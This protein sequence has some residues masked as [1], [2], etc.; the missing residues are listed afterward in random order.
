[1]VT[2]RQLRTTKEIY[3]NESR[4]QQ[5]IQEFKKLIRKLSLI[6]SEIELSSK[7]LL[8]NHVRNNISD[9]KCLKELYAVNS[10]AGSEPKRIRVDEGTSTKSISSVIALPNM[11]EQAKTDENL[12]L[13]KE[14]NTNC[15]LFR[16][17]MLELK[18]RII[19]QAEF[20]RQ[21]NPITGPASSIIPKSYNSASEILMSNVLRCESPVEI[22]KINCYT[23]FEGMD[24][25]ELII[26]GR[27]NL[28]YM[29]NWGYKANTP[30]IS[31]RRLFYANSQPWAIV[32]MPPNREAIITIEEEEND[33]NAQNFRIVIP[34]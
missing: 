7:G 10:I 18:N 28:C 33:R 4:L 24:G 32:C 25:V 17:L 9:L 20:M 23:Y 6:K 15:E 31:F 19:T 8:L 12:F 27:K 11:K 22:D 1:M 13:E 2:Q 30:N 3:E 26:V 21:L 14:I 34:G 29:F 5:Q 16:K